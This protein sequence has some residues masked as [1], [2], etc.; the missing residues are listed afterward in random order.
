M[1]GEVRTF[2]RLGRARIGGCGCKS[3]AGAEELAVV[4]VLG[5][6]TDW[7]ILSTESSA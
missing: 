4:L 5:F 2:W 3:I 7:V 1:A 6:G